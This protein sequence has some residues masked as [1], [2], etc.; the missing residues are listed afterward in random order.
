MKSSK[1]KFMPR[2]TVVSTRLT[3]NEAKSLR[4][5]AR[6]QKQNRSS[7]VRQALLKYIG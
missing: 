2:R 6:R 3:N 7:F 5:I 4:A 1:S